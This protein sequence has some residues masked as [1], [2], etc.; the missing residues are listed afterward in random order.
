VSPELL[1]ARGPRSGADVD[2]T[3]LT[4]SA[5]IYKEIGERLE[6]LLLD[7]HQKED[8]GGDKKEKLVDAE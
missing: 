1:P 6:K 3:A 2:S 5:V 8:A 7:K 4:E